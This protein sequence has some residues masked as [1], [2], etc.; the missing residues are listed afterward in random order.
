MRI[1]S[2]SKLMQQLYIYKYRMKEL[3]LEES[4]DNLSFSM[5]APFLACLFVAG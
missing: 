5:C 2:L 3:R 1:V 4:G